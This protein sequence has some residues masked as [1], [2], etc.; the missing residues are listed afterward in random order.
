MSKSAYRHPRQHLPDR[1]MTVRRNLGRAL[2]GVRPD[3]AEALVAERTAELQAQIRAAQSQV[4]R[5]RDQQSKLALE[6]ERLQR[7]ADMLKQAVDLLQ[8]AYLR[9]RAQ[10]ETARRVLTEELA[11]MDRRHAEHLQDLRFAQVHADAELQRSTR[12][13]SDL[14]TALRRIL[15]AHGRIHTELAP[16]NEPR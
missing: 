13:I 3:V 10:S 7:R 9:E 2:W 6:I 8:D 15:S 11:Q 16:P 14:I 1:P 4:Q 5:E 12:E